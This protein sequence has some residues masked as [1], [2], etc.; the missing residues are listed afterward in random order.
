M[1]SWKI[2]FLLTLAI[3]APCAAQSTIYFEGFETGAVGW[4]FD[5]AVGGCA[6]AVDGAPATSFG[7]FSCGGLGSPVPQPTVFAGANA[8]NFNNGVDMDYGTATSTGNSATGPLITLTS[9]AGVTMTIQDFYEMDS[10]AKPNAHRRFVEWLDAGGVVL[11]SVQLTYSD[12]VDAEESCGGFPFVA[13]MPGNWNNDHVHTF[14]ISTLGALTFRLRFRVELDAAAGFETSCSG[15]FVDNINIICPVADAAAPTTPSQIIPAAASTVVSPVLFDWTDSTDTG[16]CGPGTVSYEVNIVPILP[17]GLPLTIP[18]GVSTLLQPLPAGS[19]TWRVRSLDGTG[20]SAGFT[21]T[22]PFNVEVN[23]APLAPDS[24]FVNESFDSAQTGDPG[25]V[26]PVIDQQ[27]NFSAVYR[28]ANVAPDNAVG[29]RFQVSIDPL[30]LSLDFDSGPV[31]ISP[32]VVTDA[33]CLDL[34]INVSLLRNTVYYWRIQFTDLGGLT[35]PFSLPQSF[36]IGDDF[37]FGVR[38]GSTHHG[39]RC[40]IATAA[41]GSESAAPVV[42]LQ[43]WRSSTLE[44]AAAG[45]AASRTYHAVGAVAS[46]SIGSSALARVATSGFSETLALALAAAGLLIV[47]AGCSRFFRA[48]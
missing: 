46:A 19:Y 30:F 2:A 12:G 9:L 11:K 23:L 1:T 36:R 29:L 39:R 21:A 34:T 25:F 43:R 24:L 6:W 5:P 18:V 27:P 7:L 14:N 41:W 32:S 42:A 38:G 37:E 10:C 17:P 13:G 22:I 48:S 15:W 47:L 33:R 20:N 4:T 31:G 26:N 16:P 40:W 45:Q 28:D 8:L 44:S 35:G 3:S